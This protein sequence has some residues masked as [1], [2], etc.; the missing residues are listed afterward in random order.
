M[1]EI[2]HG[3]RAAEASVSPTEV[4]PIGR[5]HF[6]RPIEGPVAPQMVD[7][8]GQ[9]RSDSS[10]GDVAEITTGPSVWEALE[11]G[12]DAR[13]RSG[14]SADPC[15]ALARAQAGDYAPRPLGDTDI[16]DG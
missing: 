14:E 12:D 11:A 6:S 1:S 2:T 16:D 10:F 4:D 8:R 13:V 15:D 3:D 7:D 9:A 5:V